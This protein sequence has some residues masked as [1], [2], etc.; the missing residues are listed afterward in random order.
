[1]GWA[2][3]VAGGE[4]A[5]FSRFSNPAS[6]RILD[7]VT[8]THPMLSHYNDGTS[9]PPGRFDELK[10]ETNSSH[11]HDGGHCD[12]PGCPDAD[13]VSVG[14]DAASRNQVLGFVNSRATVFPGPPKPGEPLGYMSTRMRFDRVDHYIAGTGASGISH[15]ERAW[16]G[17]AIESPP[18][19][20]PEVPE[21]FGECVTSQ[22]RQPIACRLVVRR[23]RYSVI[24]VP[25]LVEDGL[26]RVF[27]PHVRLRFRID[28]GIIGEFVEPNPTFS[29]PWQDPA[30]MGLMVSHVDADGEPTVTPRIVQ[31]GNP[32]G[33]AVDR[34]TYRNVDGEILMPSLR[35]DW[36]GYIG[37]AS[38]PGQRPA[39]NGTGAALPLYGMCA[40]LADARFRAHGWPTFV[41]SRPESPSLLYG[42]EVTLYF[43][44]Q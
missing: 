8:Y 5:C 44:G 25:E 16:D 6:V 3:R 2:S 23:V 22:S 42:G 36:M 17:V 29:R 24:L 37:A 34:I 26:R 41:G 12:F 30:D 4:G 19:V 1:M 9:P 7:G 31:M 18:E 39:D 13:G 32:Q 10:F 40:N 11:F 20:W 14:P 33:V 27:R 35:V 43:G 38:K 28:L 21:V 15:F